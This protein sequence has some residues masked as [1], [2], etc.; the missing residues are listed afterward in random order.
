[1][2][3][4]MNGLCSRCCVASLHM[5]RARG[6]PCDPA[7]AIRGLRRTLSFCIHR[8]KLSAIRTRLALVLYRRCSVI[9]ARVRVCVCV[10]RC[11]RVCVCVCVC[12]CARSRYNRLHR[13]NKCDVAP[14][15]TEHLHLDSYYYVRFTGCPSLYDLQLADDI[16][17]GHRRL[18]ERDVHGA[19]SCARR[20]ASTGARCKCIT[21][22]PYRRTPWANEVVG[23][24]S[25][26]ILPR[27]P[28]TP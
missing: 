19:N 2:R 9:R 16:D 26:L 3:E 11:V 8:A 15:N 21:V 20:P 25:G 27:A 7:H 22:R 17:P 13:I 6:R 10:C 18:T 12:V 24:T 28:V 4:W 1:M 23:C 14:A 5:A